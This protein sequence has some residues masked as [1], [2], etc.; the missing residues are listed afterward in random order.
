MRGLTHPLML[1]AVWVS[2]SLFGTTSP[3][4]ADLQRR[5]LTPSFTYNDAPNLL[6]NAQGIFLFWSAGSGEGQVNNTIQQSFFKDGQWSQPK[7]VIEHVAASNGV[8]LPCWNPVPLK[9]PGNQTALFFQVGRTREEWKG[10]VMFSYDGGHSWMK[11]H[12]LPRGIHGA[13][14]NKPLLMPDGRFLC[15]SSN[16]E[17]GW[18]VQLEWATPFR[19]RWGWSRTKPLNYPGEYRAT[20]PAI[21]LHDDEHIQILCRSKQGY[22]T[23]IWS[24]DSGKTWGSMKRGALPNPGSSMDV[25][26]LEDGRFAM[27]Y[28]HSASKSDR[29]HL[30]LSQDGVHWQGAAIL[31]KNPAQHFDHPSIIQT[32]NG[33]LHIVYSVNRR[34]LHHLEINPSSLEGAPI[35]NE[36]WPVKIK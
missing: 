28:S 32:Q 7:Q 6:A 4:A 2:V 22:M 20:D 23:E 1:M 12:A 10:R 26:K 16:E 30:A 19:E 9:G 15:P 34:H 14:K 25:I 5:V 17:A 33:Q 29:M 13:T 21:L 36:V 8:H 35:V 24:H 27:V 3:L 31:D 18:R 11:D